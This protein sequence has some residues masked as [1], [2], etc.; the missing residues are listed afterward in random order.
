MLPRGVVGTA[1]ELQ[2]ASTA[3]D[4]RVGIIGDYLD[5]FDEGDATCV[6][7]VIEEALGRPREQQTRR[8]QMEVAEILGFCD[9][10]Y[11]CRTY[12]LLTGKTFSDR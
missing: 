6:V 4:A 10:P 8:E 2:A 12:K 1:A 3:T 11:L 5:R 9:A 7:Q